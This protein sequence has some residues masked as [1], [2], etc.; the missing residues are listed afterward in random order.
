LGLNI[1]KNNVTETELRVLIY[2]DGNERASAL[3]RCVVVL[4][5]ALIARKA[6]C[7]ESS[8]VGNVGIL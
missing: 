5:E 6:I 8:V 7:S 3:E 4:S 2:K 1:V